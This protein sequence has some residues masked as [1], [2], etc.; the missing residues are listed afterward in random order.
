MTATLQIPDL[1]IAPSGHHRSSSRILTEEL[2]TNISAIF[3]FE[4]LEVAIRCAIHQLDER[5]I[6]I[7]GEELIPFT[8]PND[9]E[10]VPPSATEERFELLDDLSISTDR[11]IESL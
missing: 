3:R 4:S 11:A 5:A 10:N 9:L 6:A 1:V 2:L 8:A 7:L